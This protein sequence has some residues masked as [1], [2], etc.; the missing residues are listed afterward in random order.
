MW[1]STEETVPLRRALLIQGTSFL[2]LWAILPCSGGHMGGGYPLMT[3]S[4]MKILAAASCMIALCVAE[5]SGGDR[6][7]GRLENAL[8]SA[9]EDEQ[10]AVWVFFIDKGETGRPVPELVSPVALL[11]R[12]RVLPAN[13]LVDE[14]DLPVSTEYIRAL[15]PLVTRIRQTSKWLNAV[16][17][18]ATRAGVARLESLPF[19]REI[20]IVQKYRRA[21]GT[22]IVQSTPPLPSPRI[23]SGTGALDYGPSLDQVLPEN[24]PAVHATGNSAQGIIIGLFDNGVRLQ[25]HQAFDSLRGR[26]IAQRDFVDH[27]TSVIPNNPNSVFGGHGVNTL[28]TLAGYRPGQIIGPAYGASFI[29]ARTENDSSETPFEE[30]N[31]AAAIEWAESLGVQVTSTSLGYLTFDSPYTSLTWQDMNGRTSVISRAATMAAR[32]GVIV[33]NSAGNE[34]LPVPP[35]QNSLIAPADADSILTAGAVSPGGGRAGFSSCGPTS[36][37]RIKPDVMAVGSLVYVASNID[38]VGYFYTQGT[39]FSCPLTAGVAA[40]VLRAHPEATAMQIIKAIKTTAYR[41]AGQTTRPDN[42]D[43]WGIIDAVAAINYLGSGSH[44]VPPVALGM[45]DRSTTGFT[46]NWTTVS[47]AM[48]YGLDVAADSAFSSLVQAYTN[49]KVDYDVTRYAVKN[50]TAGTSYYYRVRAIGTG[51]TSGNSNIIAASTIPPPAKEFTLSRNYPNPFNPGTRIEFQ[52]PE[53]SRVK[54][55]VFDILGR[56]VKTLVDAVFPASG[57]TPYFVLWDGTDNSGAGVASGVYFYRMDA[58]GVSG[59]SSRMVMKMMI[60]R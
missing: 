36:D 42:L 39:S 21:G 2:I 28:S 27:K 47:G 41:A 5:G 59:A 53:Q 48:S 32:R 9:R 58:T 40:L 34:Y 55:S 25:T 37:G 13:R 33:V 17:V 43:G 6:T 22:E 56:P 4:A 7:T 12:A 3:G 31:W 20:D 24:I 18:E 49:L 11:R 10:V 1:D 15:A 50:L 51:G 46:A 29:L 45:S 54:L 57:G 44:P 23:P 19:V 52:V 14:A 30:D 60:L 26:I 8:R 38:P 16:S 35:A